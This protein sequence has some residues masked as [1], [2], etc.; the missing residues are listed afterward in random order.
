MPQTPQSTQDLPGV[1]I[2]NITRTRY[3]LGDCCA[4]LISGND[5]TTLYVVEDDDCTR[6]SD[7]NVMGVATSYLLEHHAVAVKLARRVGLLHH[8][9]SDVE[10]K[11]H[12]LPHLSAYRRQGRE[13]K[14][15]YTHKPGARRSTYETTKRAE[16]T[17]RALTS[18]RSSTSWLL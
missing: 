9:P 3:H 17:L 15:P 12:Q 14:K 5:E 8:V 18:R 11:R 16:S 6:G 4:S 13:V 2:T 1:R 7:K 10:T